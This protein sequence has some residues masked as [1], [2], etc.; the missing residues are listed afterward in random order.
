[1]S[2]KASAS[3]T[4][5]EA[6]VYSRQIP[7]LGVEGQ[8]RLRRAKVAVVGLG[9][10][11]SPISLYLAAAGVSLRLVDW[12]LVELSNLN[13]Q[14][15]Y[16]RADVGRPKAYAAAER[17]GALNPSVELEPFYRPVVGRLALEVVRGVDLVL[18]AADN[19][20]VREAI[21]EAC[22]EEGV[23][24]TY[25]AVN[26]WFGAYAFF[27]RPGEDPCLACLFPQ[28]LRDHP[29]HV[30]GPVPALVGAVSAADAIKFLSG[31]GE[32]ARGRMLI[33][34]L[35]EMSFESVAVSRDPE[36]RVCARGEYRAITEDPGRVFSRKDSHFFFEPHLRPLEALRGARE[37]RWRP[38]EVRPEFARFDASGATVVTYSGGGALV[39]GVTLAEAERLIGALLGAQA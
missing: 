20:A 38:L 27:A 36:C 11:G 13:R 29:V 19:A 5:E 33:F 2:P 4:E 39:K 35:R 32:P 26:R 17:L 14:V 31:A 28:G 37:L 6:E 16:S 23:P 8:E 9:G 18:D 25:A 21:N 1:M 34:D 22:V 12:D 15:L 3:L 24:H 30:V 7:L 10:L